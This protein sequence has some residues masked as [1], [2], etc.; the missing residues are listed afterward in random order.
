M[1]F[2]SILLILLIIQASYGQ[3]DLDSIAKTQA[4][5]TNSYYQTWEKGNDETKEFYLFI[6]KFNDDSIYQ[7]ESI[8]FPLVTTTLTGDPTDNNYE[9]NTI[10][11][12]EYRLI[13]FTSQNSNILDGEI[14]LTH[15]VINSTHRSILV[16][17]EDTGIHIEYFFEHL[18]QRWILQKVVDAST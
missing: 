14:I 6:S 10:E 12:N 2:L 7:L 11:K 9:T 15:K 1:K 13:R 16:Q 8:A 3:N 17:Q 5:R 4:D 18:K